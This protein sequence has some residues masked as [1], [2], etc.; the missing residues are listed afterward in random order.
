[1]NKTEVMIHGAVLPWD[2]R[3]HGW[4]REKV[5]EKYST[6]DEQIAFLLTL[7]TITKKKCDLAI[8]EYV[9]TNRELK[10]WNAS[11]VAKLTRTRRKLN[12]VLV[13]ENF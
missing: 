1:M 8:E 6:P 7:L 10:S 13:E 4:T 9:V 2:T 12:D 11:L 5:C 3:E